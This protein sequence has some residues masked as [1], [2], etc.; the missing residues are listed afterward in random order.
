[1]EPVTKPKPTC[2]IRENDPVQLPP[3]V[4]R[5]MF[6]SLSPQHRLDYGNQLFFIFIST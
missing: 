2:I 6:Y 5:G 3:D 1:M 4:V